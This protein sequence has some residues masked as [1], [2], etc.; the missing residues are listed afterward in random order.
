MTSEFT[1]P[2]S[3]VFSGTAGPGVTV[4]LN[5]AFDFTPIPALP[6]TAGKWILRYEF[7]AINFPVLTVDIEVDV[8]QVFST[9]EAPHARLLSQEL[10]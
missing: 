9:H 5:S 3:A 6:M 7:F 8:P 2:V 4:H 1:Q 10:A